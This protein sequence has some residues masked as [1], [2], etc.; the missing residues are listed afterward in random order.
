MAFGLVCD[1]GNIYSDTTRVQSV[2]SELGVNLMLH[3]ITEKAPVA[4]RSLDARLNGKRAAQRT[5][6]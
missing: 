6:L 5:A 3:L 2:K 4:V 1:T